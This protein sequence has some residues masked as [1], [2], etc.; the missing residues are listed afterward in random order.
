MGRCGCHE[1]IRWG[2][3]GAMKA[4]HGALCAMKALHG[5]LEA[6]HGADWVP[7]TQTQMY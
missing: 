7:Y 2:I 4:L 6:S 5:G 1:G 3:V